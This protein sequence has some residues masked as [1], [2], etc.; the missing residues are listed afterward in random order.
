[1]VWSATFFELVSIEGKELRVDIGYW[2]CY[3]HDT[4]R[5]Q[6]EVRYMAYKFDNHIGFVQISKRF[7]GNLRPPSRRWIEQVSKYI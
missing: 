3:V 1:M 5:I 4:R 6:L 2:G 7:A